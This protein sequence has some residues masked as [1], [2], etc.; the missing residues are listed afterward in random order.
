MEY[1]ENSEKSVEK[2][3]LKN[4]DAAA[5]ER[6][7]ADKESNKE[8]FSFMQETIKDE[9]GGFRKNRSMALKCAGMGLIFGLA[10]C[11]GFCALKPWAEEHFAGNPKEITIPEEDEEQ[12]Q[13][14]ETQEKETAPNLTLEDYEAMNQA[15]VNVASDVSRSMVEI[16]VR[17]QTPGEKDDSIAGVIFEDNGAELLV[18]GQNFAVPEGGTLQARLADNRYY[19]IRMKKQDTNLG[20]AVYA[21]QKNEISDSTWNQIKTAVLGS[22]GS[23]TKGN[24]VMAIGS[25]FGYYG[26]MG[27]GIVSSGRNVVSK[28]DGEYGLLCTD[29]GSSVNG[30]G[31]LANTKG[32]IVGLIDQ[33]L[34]YEDEA[35]PVTAYGISDLK[36]ALEFL[37]NDQAV[38]YMGIAGVTVTDDLNSSQG[39]PAGVYVREVNADSPAMTAG[40]QSGDILTEMNGTKIT[41]ISGYNSVLMK[42]EEGDEIRVKGLRQGTGGYVDISFKVTVGSKS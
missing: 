17:T 29:I 6:K 40:I 26:G 30:S 5:Q 20:I 8:E 39:L 7:D 33:R 28:Y 35:G 25:P 23:M 10:A 41:T 11:L 42:L 9:N 18:A 36:E 3:T 2:N 13:E 15:L 12:M 38:P 16:S 31:I 27:F 34:L 19:G 37:S 32:E 21:I 1:H 24:I 4:P 22:S 14:G